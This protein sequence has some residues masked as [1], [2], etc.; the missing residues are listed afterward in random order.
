VDEGVRDGSIPPGVDAAGTAWRLAATGDGI[1]SM[2][3]L[4][5]LRPQKGRALV[6]AG[7]RNE[8]ER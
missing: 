1:D 6:R 5:L 3:Y 8:L 4:G 2:L 7:I